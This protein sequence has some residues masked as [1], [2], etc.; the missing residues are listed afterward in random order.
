MDLFELKRQIQHKSIY[1][2]YVFAGEETGIMKIYIDQISKLVNKSVERLDTVQD[3]YERIHKPSL[4]KSSKVFVVQDDKSFL[5]NEKLWNVIPKSV[6]NNNL[7][8]VFTKADKRSKF[9][10]QVDYVPFNPMPPEVL[11]KYI[12]KQLPLSES[13]SRNL[14]EICECSYDRCLQECYKIQSYMHYRES[15]NDS[16][17]ADMAYRLMLNEGVIYKPIGDITFDFVDAIMDRGPIARIEDLMIKVRTKKEPRL[18]LISLLYKNFRNL[19]MCQSLGPGRSDYDKIT[20]LSKFEVNVAR[21]RFGNYN[22]AELKRA[23]DILQ[24]LEFGVKTGSV[25]ELFS[26]DYFIAQVI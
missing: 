2:Y 21:N 16:I 22:T 17:T 15:V 5:K 13:N 23:M 25:E 11:S 14:A 19:F 6:K 20:G 18:L 3:V 8:L 10:K 7:I 4:V 1:N 26:I 24:K 12:M 9:F